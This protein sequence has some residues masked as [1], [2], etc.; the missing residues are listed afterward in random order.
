MKTEW[1]IRKVRKGEKKEG[2]RE[3]EVE[4]VMES[5]RRK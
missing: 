3:R 1:K 2:C 5:E 4:E